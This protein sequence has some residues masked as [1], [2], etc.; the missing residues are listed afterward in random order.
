MLYNKRNNASIEKKVNRK[1]RE[2]K[3][4]KANGVNNKRCK[5]SPLFH[6]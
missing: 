3:C 4:A 5:K 1:E 2:E 6:M